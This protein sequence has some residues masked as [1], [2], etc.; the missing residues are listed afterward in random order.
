[1]RS[2]N[3]YRKTDEKITNTENNEKFVEKR[4]TGASEIAQKAAGKGG[5]SILTAWHFK[6]KDGPY[7]ESLKAIKDGKPIS[8]FD[9]KYKTT[10]SKLHASGLHSQKEFQKIMGELEVFGEI[11][12]QLRKGGTY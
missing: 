8:F 10:M 11:L 5:Y 2:Y 3:E 12:I 4:K 7:K 6:S 9:D 1:M